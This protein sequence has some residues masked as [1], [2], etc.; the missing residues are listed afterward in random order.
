[1][2][3]PLISWEMGWWWGVGRYSAPF[4]H[5]AAGQIFKDDVNGFSSTSDICFIPFSDGSKLSRNGGGDFSPIPSPFPATLARIHYLCYLSLFTMILEYGKHMQDF[6][7]IT[8]MMAITQ[9]LQLRSYS[10]YCNK[11]GLGKG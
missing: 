2:K 6:V 7:G 1:M 10:F 8:K 4:L 9:N 5:Q 3:Y 11:E